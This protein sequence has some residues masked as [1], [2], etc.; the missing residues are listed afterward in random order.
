ME[1]PQSDHL[2]GP[3]VSLG[4]FGDVMQLLIDV[5]EQGGDKIHGGHAALLSW[6]GCHAASV[7][8]SYDDCK[9]K[10]VIC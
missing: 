8:E 2:T 10:N 3:E 7:E 4:M 5:I 6:E 9:P 1:Q